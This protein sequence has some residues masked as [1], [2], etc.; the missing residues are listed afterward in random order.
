MRLRQWDPN[1]ASPLSSLV[2]P[3]ADPLWVDQFHALHG[4]DRDEGD[5]RRTVVAV[6]DSDRMIGCATVTESALH[7]GRFPCAI[8]VAPRARRSGIGRRLLEEMKALRPDQSRPL[9]TKVRRSNSA[10]MAFVSAVGGRAYQTSPGI[11]LDPRASSIQRWASSRS[12]P[13]CRTMVS[14]VT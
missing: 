13:D 14:S 6:D 9:S 7:G 11:V 12:C 10:A 5:W 4:P 3:D 1:D 8:D 2:Q